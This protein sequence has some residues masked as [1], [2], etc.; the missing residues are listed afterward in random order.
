MILEL[1]INDF[2]NELLHTSICIDVSYKVV[3]LT[4]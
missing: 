3:K 4:I 2:M 1:N